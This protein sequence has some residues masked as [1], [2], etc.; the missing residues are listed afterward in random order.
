MKVTSKQYGK[1]GRIGIKNGVQDH[2][3]RRIEQKLVDAGLFI[4]WDGKGF[5][6]NDLEEA[7]R[8]FANKKKDSA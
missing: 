3:L 4:A 6:V 5:V 2:I 8:L 1:V 7:R